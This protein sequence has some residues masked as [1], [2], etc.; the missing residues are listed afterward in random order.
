MPLIVNKD[1]MRKGII[2]AFQECINVKPLTKITMRD[3][4]EYAKM[5]HAKILYYFK[6]K[7]EL[8]LCYIEYIAELYSG[9]F[10]TWLMEKTPG[11]GM[12]SDYLGRKLTEMVKYDST[13]HSKAFTQ[14]YVLGQYD[15][16]IKAV[17][18]DTY[19][20][21]R[22]SLEKS[23]RELCGHSMEQEAEALLV[24]VEGLLLYSMNYSI[25][26]NN[27]RYILNTYSGLLDKSAGN[28]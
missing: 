10:S 27:V 14:I 28:C 13:V 18:E 12:L 25:N 20:K 6:N 19:G 5:S 11:E 17:I 2:I 23:L 16:A 26:E 24:L 22:M 21:W 4:A 7:E 9:Y 1:E 8:I 3:I 15:P